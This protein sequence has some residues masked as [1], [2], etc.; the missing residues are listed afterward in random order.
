MKSCTCPLCEK[1][2][3]AARHQTVANTMTPSASLNGTPGRPEMVRAPITVRGEHLR[4]FGQFEWRYTP[5]CHLCECWIPPSSP[6]WL[7]QSAIRRA[8][9]HLKEEHAR[10]L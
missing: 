5:L 4:C 2:D 7:F 6:A 10:D 9:E 3:Q 8:A 1:P